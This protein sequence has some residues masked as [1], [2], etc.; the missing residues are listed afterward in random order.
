M[1]RVMRPGRNGAACLAVGAVLGLRE[2]VGRDVRGVRS[3]VRDD[4]HLRGPCRHVYGDHGLAVLQQH[5]CGRH[6]LVPRAQQLVHL[7]QGSISTGVSC[8]GQACCT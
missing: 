3:T 7:V 6:V 2:Q 1:V 4:Q 5:L 8:A